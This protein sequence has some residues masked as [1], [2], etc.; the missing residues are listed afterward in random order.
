MKVRAAQ[1]GYNFPYVYDQSQQL[2]RELGATHTPEFFVFNKQRKLVYTGLM[3]DSPAA[4][5]TDGTINYT[6]GTPTEFH[7]KDA[8]EAA[9]AGRPAAVSETRPQ[10]CSIAYEQGR[11]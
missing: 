11:Q 6:R 10:G 1:T 9:L 8:V 4:M 7:V 5:R 3:N 2:G